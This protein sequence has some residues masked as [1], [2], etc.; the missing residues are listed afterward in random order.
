MNTRD[1]SNRGDPGLFEKPQQGQEEWDRMD[2]PH[3]TREKRIGVKK[4]EIAGQARG[5]RN[6]NKLHSVMQDGSWLGE[7]R[8]TRNSKFTTRITLNAIE[9]TSGKPEA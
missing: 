8:S 3:S 2:L 9:V 7:A 1:T 6:S 5:T 4:C